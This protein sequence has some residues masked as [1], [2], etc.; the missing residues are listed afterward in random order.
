MLSWSAWTN[1][2]QKNYLCNVDPQSINN[3]AQENNLILSGSISVNIVQRNFLCN[4]GPWLTGNIFEGNNAAWT[5]LGQ[6]WIRLLSSQYCLLAFEITLHKK[7]ACAIL[8]QNAQTCFRRKTGY[9]FKGYVACFLTGAT[10]PKNLG[11]FLSVLV[12]NFIYDLR[13]N[14]AEADIDWN[15]DNRSQQTE[16]S[17][18]PP[19]LQNKLPVWFIKSTL[20][21]T[22]QEKR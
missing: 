20:R 4:V 2:A 6:H 14:N 9:S 1:I 22:D 18:W 16:S 21:H 5:I 3:F 15:T 13:N 10:S 11:A 12:W 7:T 8:I 17:Y 19:F